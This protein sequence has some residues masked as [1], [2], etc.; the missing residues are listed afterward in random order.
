MILD[1]L[2]SE[3]DVVENSVLRSVVEARGFLL[4]NP[5]G[6]YR[7]LDE[8]YTHRGGSLVRR[9]SRPWNDHM[10]PE[11]R[12][13]ELEACDRAFSQRTVGKSMRF[14]SR[15]RIFSCR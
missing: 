7:P 13:L 2:C 9:V 6:S 8:R 11:F 1:G 12:Q 5:E 4:G 14:G 3:Q 15:E 10:T